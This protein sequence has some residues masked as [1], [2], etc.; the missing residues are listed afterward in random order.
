MIYFANGYKY[1]IPEDKLSAFLKKYPEAQLAKTYAVGSELYE[2]P[3]NIENTFLSKYPQATLK[4]QPKPQTFRDKLS[5]KSLGVDINKET[6]QAASTGTADTQKAQFF[7]SDPNAGYEAGKA[8]AKDIYGYNKAGF[9]G[10]L[11]S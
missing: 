3:A 7:K 2:I 4:E 6:A 5:A 8:K 9:I 1:D 11:V 10:D